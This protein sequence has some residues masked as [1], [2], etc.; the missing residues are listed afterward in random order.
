MSEGKATKSEKREAARENARIA[1]AQEQKRKSRNRS[2][3]QISIVIGILTVAAIT[4]SVVLSGAGSKASENPKNM[5][6]DGAVVAQ[7]L[8]VQATAAVKGNAPAPTEQLKT[9]ANIVIYLDYLC[10][11]CGQFEKT[12]TAELESLV[13]SGLATVEYHPIA[14]LG[15]YS[16]RAANAVACVVDSD[17]KHFWAYNTALFVNEP[18]EAQAGGLPNKKLIT[19][20][21]DV[22]VDQSII[23]SCVNNGTFSKWVT[24]STQRAT[25]KAIPNS[26]LAQVSST[27]TV[28]VDGQQFT[29]NP[30]DANAFKAFVD[31]ALAKKQ[32]GK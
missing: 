11:Y 3:T 12:N 32:V 20:A 7:G 29:G 13:N 18:A 9:K 14:I 19:L 1:R 2:V 4:V 21:G 26:K 15:E 6:S 30:L 23:T 22:G 5:A 8:I 27:P 31:A 16:A 28:L 25:G 24:N 17:P 10:P